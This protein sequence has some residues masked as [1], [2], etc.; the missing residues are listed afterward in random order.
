MQS[1]AVNL[2]DSMQTFLTNFP[3]ERLPMDI[4]HQ[5]VDWSDPKDV[6]HLALA[7]KF[8]LPLRNELFSKWKTL[9]IDDTRTDLN[10]YSSFIKDNIQSV[11]VQT[12]DLNLASLIMFQ[13]LQYL[14][15]LILTHWYHWST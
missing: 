10:E 2:E 6:T 13:N 4:L 12:W 8:F 7:S 11:K 15:L 9:I 14:Q 3:L 1:S 5:I